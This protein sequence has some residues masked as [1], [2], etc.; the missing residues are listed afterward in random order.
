MIEREIQIDTADGSMTTFVYHPEHDG[1]SP[2]VLYMMDAP[3]IRPELQE[4]AARLASAGYYVMLPFLFYRGISYADF[5]KGELDWEKLRPMIG[6]ITNTS[7]VGDARAALAVADHDRAARA[8]SVGVVGFCMGGSL[9]VSIARALPDRVAAAASIHGG[10]LVTDAPD[11]PHTGLDR[12]KAEL[13]FAWCDPDSSAPSE[14]IPVMQQALDDAGVRATIDVITTA[15][16]GF[17]P[18][19]SERYD[20]AASELHWERVQSLLRRN[21]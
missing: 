21:L 17:A 8:G 19:G 12:V 6:T 3:G 15:Q 11:S 7:V 16:H 20:R 13:Y 14:T 2:V 5:S 10:R 1:P 9:A 18:P 4:M